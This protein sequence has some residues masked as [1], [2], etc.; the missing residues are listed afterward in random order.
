MVA[1]IQRHTGHRGKRE[2]GGRR[3]EER[4]RREEERRGM[5]VSKRKDG[6]KE[7]MVWQ[8]HYIIK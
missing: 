8:R 5:K 6:R 4:R 2:E 1:V 7:E 3:K